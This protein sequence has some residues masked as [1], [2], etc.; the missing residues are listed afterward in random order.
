MP[1]IAFNVLLAISLFYLPWWT[2]ALI[3]VSACFL[4]DHFYEAVLFGMLADAF[5][6]TEF[7]FHGFS[8]I[9]ALYTAMVLGF[10]SIVRN[11]LA[12]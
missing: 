5:Y 11:R 8:H 9:A 2:G 12:W 3:V 7:G 1:R 4:V 6:G 10:A